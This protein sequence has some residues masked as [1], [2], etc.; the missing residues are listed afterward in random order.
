MDRK[1]C[2]VFLLLFA[3]SCFASDERSPIAGNPPPTRSNVSGARDPIALNRAIDQ[4]QLLASDGEPLSFFGNS[5]A[6]SGDT[7]VVGSPGYDDGFGN[8]VPG[9]A[10]VFVKP[11]S[12]WGN[13]IQTAELTASDGGDEAGNYFGYSVAIANDTIIVGCPGLAQAYVYVKSAGGWENMTETAILTDPSFPQ[14][15][16]FG[17]AVAIDS[18][19]QTVAVGAVYETFDNSINGAG[20]V[21]VKPPSGWQ[22]TSTANALL[23]ASNG[24][25]NDHLGVSAAV[26]GNT[27]VLG[28]SGKPY[29]QAFGAAYVYVMPEGGW[30]NMTQTAALTASSQETGAGLGASITISGNTIA[31]GAPGGSNSQHAGNI[32]VFDEPAGGWSNMTQTAQVTNGDGAYDSLGASVALIENALVAGAPTDNVGANI[33]QGSAYVFLKP[34]SGWKSTSQFYTRLTAS[35]GTRM[36]NLGLSVAAGPNTAVAGAPG[37]FGGIDVGYGYVFFV[38]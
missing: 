19:A 3:V 27:V 23:T 37:A 13:M 31:A 30:T 1:R 28:A 11:A 22:N 15:S 7:I 26:E 36:D 20:Y 18:T 16:G 29:P 10:Y 2:L 35:N 33:K 14:D 21:F 17:W 4:A 5:V 9:Y 8:Y 38:K 12:G 34:K 24:A 6:I 32:F 25:Q